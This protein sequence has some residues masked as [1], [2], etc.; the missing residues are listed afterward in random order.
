VNDRVVRLPPI[1]LGQGRVRARDPEQPKRRPVTDRGSVVSVHPPGRWNCDIVHRPQISRREAG[2]SFELH[3]QL[4]GGLIRPQ[5]AAEEELFLQPSP[6]A[7][8]RSRRPLIARGVRNRDAGRLPVRGEAPALGDAKSSAGPVVTVHLPRRS[9]A[10][11][12]PA[13]SD[14]DVS[15]L[16][17]ERQR[18]RAPPRVRTRIRV[19]DRE[20]GR[21]GP[22]SRLGPHLNLYVQ[23]P[24]PSRKGGHCPRRKLFGRRPVEPSF[25][26]P[27]PGFGPAAALIGHNHRSYAVGTDRGGV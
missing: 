17:G 20:A 1:A 15:G 27:E 11:L 21:R 25:V 8:L 10:G 16:L 18:L 4:P 23:P 2:A 19:G 13:E 14:R 24:P 7:G 6:A 3:P 12:E 26:S 22:G 9:D 5:P